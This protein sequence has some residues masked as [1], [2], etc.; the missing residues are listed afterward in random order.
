[1]E[2]VAEF[3][4]SFIFFVGGQ[5]GRLIAQWQITATRLQCLV[6][7]AYEYLLTVATIA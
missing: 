3:L 6:L 1:M 4:L 7:I 2:G 5:V